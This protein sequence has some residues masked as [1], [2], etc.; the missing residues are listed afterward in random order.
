VS[1]LAYVFFAVLLPKW[2]NYTI[3]QSLEELDDGAMA[4]GLVKVP[5]AELEAWDATHDE[6]GAVIANE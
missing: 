2:G 3:R 6:H 5:N 4:T 1:G